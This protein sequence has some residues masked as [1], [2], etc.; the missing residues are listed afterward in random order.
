MYTFLVFVLII[1]GVYFIYNSLLKFTKIQRDEFTNY[2]SLN[3]GKK[4]NKQKTFTCESP[5]YIRRDSI[6]CFRC[7]LPKPL[8]ASNPTQFNLYKNPCDGPEYIRKDR[9]PCWG[10]TLPTS[11]N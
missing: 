3:L 5:E 11:S 4:S 8:N 1:L 6:P 2:L 10:C 7:V 9:I